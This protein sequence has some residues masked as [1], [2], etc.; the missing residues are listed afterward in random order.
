MANQKLF[1]YAILW[2]PT[3]KQVKD[4]GAKSKV[5]VEPKTVLAVDQNGA[6]MA[7]AMDIPTDYKTQLDQVEIALRSF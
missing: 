2:H 5:I 4:D 1:Q 3:E 7:A 6:A